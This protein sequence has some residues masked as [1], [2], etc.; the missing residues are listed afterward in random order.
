[1]AGKHNRTAVVEATDTDHV[2]VTD[3]AAGF[4]TIKSDGTIAKISEK[5]N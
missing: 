1:M 2:D 3:R 4:Y 5:V